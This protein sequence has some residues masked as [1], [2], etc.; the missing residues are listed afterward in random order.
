M[1][2]TQ[3]FFTAEAYTGRKGQYVSLNNTLIGCE[4]ILRGDL[5]KVSESD[6]YLTGAVD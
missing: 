5:D 3:P 2:L 1:F 6:L 4:R